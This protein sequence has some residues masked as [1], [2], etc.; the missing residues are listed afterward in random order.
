MDASTRV[1]FGT[2][3]LNPRCR[4]EPGSGARVTRADTSKEGGRVLVCYSEIMIREIRA[5]VLAA[6]LAACGLPLAARA[7][8]V[9]PGELGNAARLGEQ[10]QRLQQE[11]VRGYEPDSCPPSA[12]LVCYSNHPG[13]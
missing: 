1:N 11:L 3:M 10:L 4:V 12:E 7:Q 8:S 6:V 2:R 9:T 13:V 5:A